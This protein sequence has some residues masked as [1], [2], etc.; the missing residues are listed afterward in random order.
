MPVIAPELIL[1]S[2]PLLIT[3]TGIDDGEGLGRLVCRT[4]LMTIGDSC[5]DLRGVL[6]TASASDDTPKVLATIR[7]MFVNDW[8]AI[9]A[10]K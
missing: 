10:F 2:L 6:A 4:V 5:E 8:S 1:P 7:R 9:E 3:F